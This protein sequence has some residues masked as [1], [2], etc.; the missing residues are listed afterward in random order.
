MYCCFVKIGHVGA[1]LLTF[2]SVLLLALFLSLA[3]ISRAGM[4][5]KLEESFAIFVLFF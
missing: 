4:R 1:F 3:Q 5:L 2:T